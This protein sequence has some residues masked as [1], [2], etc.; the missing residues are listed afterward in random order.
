MGTREHRIEVL[1]TKGVESLGGMCRSWKKS[2]VP[3]VPEQIVLLKGLTYFVEVKTSDGDLEETQV[4]EH[5]RFEEQ[6]IKIIVIKG[7]DDL[8]DFLEMLKHVITSKP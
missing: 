1:L 2:N 4:R 5:K 7:Y 3:G 6:G 8:S